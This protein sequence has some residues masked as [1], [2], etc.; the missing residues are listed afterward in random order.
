M[1]AASYQAYKTHFN[2][3][4]TT[5]VHVRSDMHA[6]CN[7]HSVEARPPFPTTNHHRR[8]DPEQHA[9]N[10]STVGEHHHV[11][12]ATRIRADISSRPQDQHQRAHAYAAAC[13]SA[14]PG[15]PCALACRRPPPS[16][17]T[18]ASTTPRSTIDQTTDDNDATS[19]NTDDAFERVRR[20]VRH[21]CTRLID[22]S[23]KN[24]RPTHLR[25]SC[26]L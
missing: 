14:S 5:Y 19:R 10:G 18:T 13:S 4:S 1:P 22:H 9:R 17:P 3:R 2:R 15:A 7:P 16:G 12:R 11:E 21:W 6:D 8:P 24:S 25:Y 26:Y 23:G 20:H